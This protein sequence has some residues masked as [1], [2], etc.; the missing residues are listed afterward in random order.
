MKKKVEAKKKKKVY[1]IKKC[2]RCYA[3]IREWIPPAYDPI[4]HK[5][6][7]QQC[8]VYFFY[9]CTEHR[10]FFSKGYAVYDAKRLRF[11]KINGGSK[12]VK[13]YD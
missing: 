7:C 13:I 1:I 2:N 11:D 9:E 10:W 12:S 4:N 5:P 8:S 3:S 6:I